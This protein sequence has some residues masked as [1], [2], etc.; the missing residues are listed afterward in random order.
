MSYDPVEQHQQIIMGHPID[1]PWY[2]APEFHWMWTS[3]FV[4]IA[5]AILIYIVNKLMKRK[6]KNDL[7]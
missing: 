6:K 3:V 5:I 1:V 2:L 7:E 4:P